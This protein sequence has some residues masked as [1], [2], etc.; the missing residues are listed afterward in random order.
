MM[1]T[2]FVDVQLEV[3]SC[4]RLLSKTALLATSSRES[5]FFPFLFSAA[6]FSSNPRSVA[7]LHARQLILE[8]VEHVEVVVVGHDRKVKMLLQ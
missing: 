8:V 3:L 6:V 1:C 4:L 2:V 5:L 7:V